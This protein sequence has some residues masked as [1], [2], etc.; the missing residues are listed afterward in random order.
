MTSLFPCGSPTIP[1]LEFDTFTSRPEGTVAS[2]SSATEGG[3]AE[4]I[5]SSTSRFFLICPPFGGESLSEP[6]P[7]LIHVPEAMG[8]DSAL[9]LSLT[10]PLFD[11]RDFRNGR[12]GRRKLYRF[13]WVCEASDLVDD[14]PA[15]VGDGLVLVGDGL[16]LVG[17]VFVL[18]GDGLA[19]GDVLALAGDDAVPALIGDAL[20]LVDDAALSTAAP[21]LTCPVR[22][23]VKT[24]SFT[25]VLLS[26]T[27]D[28]LTRSCSCPCPC[29]EEWP[30]D[31]PSS[32]IGERTVGACLG[33]MC[34]ASKDSCAGGSGGAGDAGMAWTV[35]E[36]R[37]A[38]R[39][40]VSF[41]FRCCSCGR[42]C[43]WADMGM[44]CR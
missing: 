41:R 21:S 44:L 7:G 1:R 9:S 3:G 42:G 13:E 23:T 30:W 35:L 25:G 24:S 2:T 18:V 4:T 28:T 12:L 32:M 34:G 20:T 10:S 15:L 8:G 5:A 14:G 38:G 6:A 40:L 43:A 39:V 26:S 37:D 29:D 36:C 31:D 11:S 27:G 33:P 22:G 17:D 19:L 16:V